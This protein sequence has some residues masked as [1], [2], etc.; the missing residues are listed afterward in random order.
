MYNYIKIELRN[1]YKTVKL[2]SFNFTST[3]FYLA[4]GPLSYVIFTI[5]HLQAFCLRRENKH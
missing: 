4:L 3:F 1:Q 2:A 5:L